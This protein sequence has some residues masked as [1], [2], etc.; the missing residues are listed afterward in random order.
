MSEMIDIAS[1]IPQAGHMC[2]LERVLDWNDTHVRLAT[3][4]HRAADNPLRSAGRLRALHLCE[5]GAQAMAVHGGLTA[6]AAGQ[7]ARGGLLVSLRGVRLYCRFVEELPGELLVTG[8]R[9]HDGGTS[10][11]YAFSV[12]HAGVLLAEGRAAVIAQAAR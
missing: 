2:L 11:Q 6:R 3:T 9:L 1:L 4:T 10:W 5:Y 12:V 8:E 7:A